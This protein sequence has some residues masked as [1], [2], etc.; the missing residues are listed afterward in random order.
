MMVCSNYCIAENIYFSIIIQREYLHIVIIPSMSA[1]VGAVEISVTV[2]FSSCACEC[3]GNKISLSLLDIVIRIGMEIL[4]FSCQL[5]T[6]KYLKN[7]KSILIFLNNFS[8]ENIKHEQCTFYADIGFLLA[9]NTL[10]LFLCV[11]SFVRKNT[12]YFL[13]CMHAF[14]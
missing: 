7:G 2:C 12:F 5:N 6:F 9:L 1:A 10:F 4:A 14:L 13:F 3:A 8:K 11:V